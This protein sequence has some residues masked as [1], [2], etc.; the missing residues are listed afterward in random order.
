[1]TFIKSLKTYFRESDE[2]DVNLDEQNKKKR[3]KK[4]DELT[5]FSKKLEL[6]SSAMGADLSKL[7]ERYKSMKLDIEQLANELDEYRCSNRVKH[8][9]IILQ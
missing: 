8:Y 4:I 3:Q 5:E 1:M 7:T 2:E 9:S 6:E